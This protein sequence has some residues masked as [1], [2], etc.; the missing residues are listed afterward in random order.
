MSEQVAYY[1]FLAIVLGGFAIVAAGLAAIAVFLFKQNRKS[2]GMG[3]EGGGGRDIMGI[4]L[5][6]GDPGPG[7]PVR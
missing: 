4:I 6:W 2:R 1:I 5:S 3:L 7:G